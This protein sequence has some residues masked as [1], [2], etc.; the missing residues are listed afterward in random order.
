MSKKKG[1]FALKLLLIGNL[2][3]EDVGRFFYEAARS[4]GYDV[5]I[6]EMKQAYAKPSLIERVRYRLFDRK[7]KFIKRYSA[8]VVT[9]CL[10]TK[11]DLVLSTGCAPL[12]AAD[13]VKIKQLGIKTANF[14][15]DDPWGRNHKAT[16]FLSSLK[17]YDAVCTPRL[18]CIPEFI[19]L[20]IP[21]VR[22][23]AFAYHP[24]IHF[25]I[26]SKD[27]QDRFS[28]DVLFYG[29]A[30]DD[31]VELFT[32]FIGSGLNLHLYGGYWNRYPVFQRY[33]RGMLSPKD[34]PA[35][36]AAAK[37]TVCIGR[38]TNRDSHSMRS[39]EVSSM[40]GCMLVEDTEDHR[41]LYGSDADVVSYFS[42]SDDPVQ[43]SKELI[44]DPDRIEKM[45]KNVLKRVTSMPNTYADRLETIVKIF[46]ER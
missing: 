27:S 43:K 42:L 2:G 37:V 14:S 9:L 18:Q 15:T 31:R 24:P 19:K 12:L 41:N 22:Y 35:A 21:D 13:L 16:W 39:Y 8:S 23:L 4:L 40:G 7:P 46:F 29:G 25:S 11:P 3:L 10:E 5:A 45:R 32:K 17:Q 34:I 36:V 33:Y 20:G 26:P 44:A 1:T 30:D 28:C 6:H 38:K